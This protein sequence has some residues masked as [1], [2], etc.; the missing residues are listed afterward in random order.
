MLAALGAKDDNP[1]SLDADHR[2]VLEPHGPPHA[3]VEVGEGFMDSGHVVSSSGIHHPLGC[4]HMC[5]FPSNLCEHL[6]LN[7]M[8]NTARPVAAQTPE[9]KLKGEVDLK[10]ELFL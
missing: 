7:E 2:A 3:S 9:L 5:T 1:A 10:F 4:I 8:H 6:L